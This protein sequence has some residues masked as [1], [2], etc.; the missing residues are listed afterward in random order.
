MTCVADDREPAV[1]G[2]DRDGC[3][4]R[5][6]TRPTTCSPGSAA[7]CSPAPGPAWAASTSCCRPSGTSAT[8]GRPSGRSR[9][10]TSRRC[11]CVTATT[12][13]MFAN[14]CRHRGH[15]LLPDGDA[16]R[17][18]VSI[19]VPLPRLDLR[20]RGCAAGR[21]R[22]PRG[23]RL[24]ARRAR[25]G[26]AAG[27]GVGAD[28]C[29][30]TRCT[31]PARPQVPAFDDHLGAA[32][33]RRRAVRPA[34][35]GRSGTG[36]PT[37]SRANWKVVAENYHECYHC[38]LIH[39]E[40]CQVITAELRRELRPAGCVGRRVDGSP[41]RHGDDVDDR[42][43]G[44]AHRSPGST[45]RRVEYVHLLP[46]LLVS[47]HPDYVMT[48]RLVP[49]APGPHL[50]RVLVAASL[51]DADG[52]VPDPATRWSSG[53]SPTGRTGPPASRCSA[54]WPARTSRRARSRPTRTRWRSW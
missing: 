40:L 1:A 36:T 11:W 33:Q 12:V 51:P 25:A 7:T 18:A 43:A 14:T 31:R 30:G 26:R 32:R 45:R 39:P 53:T 16:S 23:R 28:G 49:L 29:S 21:A 44:G 37:R 54:G 13:R 2:R 52:T 42:G 41:R 4:R 22:V 17:T 27:D 6:P 24:R 3:C 50:D 8:A 48:H 35:A 19:A 34:R 10:G 9:S 47:A 15:E 38:P 20:P 46:N 5:R